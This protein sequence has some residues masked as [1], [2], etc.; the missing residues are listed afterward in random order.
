ML[1]ARSVSNFDRLFDSMWQEAT[2]PLFARSNG[3]AF[4]SPAF[5]VRESDDAIHFVCDVPGMRAEDL[6]VTLENDVL[7]IKGKR[8]AGEEE[9]NLYRGRRYGAFSRSF[10]LPDVVNSDDLSATLD[11]GVLTVRVGKQAKAKPRR[12]EVQVLD[13]PPQ[14]AESAE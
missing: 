14:L 12:I 9:A 1:V 8:E 4:Y 10:T 7:T 13:A 5:D 11:H 2:R 6:D 3:G